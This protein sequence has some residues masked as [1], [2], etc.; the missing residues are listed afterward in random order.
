MPERAVRRTGPGVISAAFHI[1]AIVDFTIGDISRRRTFGK[2]V[3]R[4]NLFLPER[5]RR[6]FRRL[7]YGVFLQICRRALHSFPVGV[8]LCRLLRVKCGS[9]VREVRVCIRIARQIP[10]RTV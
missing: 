8:P 7:L 1:A 3:I 9:Y 10:N 2:G 4:A 6:D 5:A